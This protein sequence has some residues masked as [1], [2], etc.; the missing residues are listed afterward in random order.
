[1][2]RRRVRLK[3]TTCRGCGQGSFFQVDGYLVCRDCVAHIDR[4][5]ADRERL[6][7]ERNNP[8]Q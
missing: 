2:C 5:I 8:R 3:W 4:A 7:R 6:Y 1:M